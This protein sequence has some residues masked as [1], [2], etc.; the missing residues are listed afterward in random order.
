MIESPGARAG[1]PSIDSG[2]DADPRGG[3]QPPKTPEQERF[4]TVFRSVTVELLPTE[5]QWKLLRYRATESMSYRN[6]HMQAVAANACGWE[7]TAAAI[8]RLVEKRPNLEWKDGVLGNGII[9]LVRN[10]EKGELSSN[11]Y[12]AAEAEVKKDW[13]RDQR[14]ILAGAPLPQYRQDKSLAIATITDRAGVVFTL[15]TYKDAKGVNRERFVVDLHVSDK[16]YEGGGWM[17]IPVHS[18]A[19]YDR[20]KHDPFVWSRLLAFANE[21][22]PIDLGRV[23]FKVRRGKTLLQISYQE[24]VPIP[25]PGE[26]VA[27]LTVYGDED[28]RL[29]L[30]SELHSVDLT[31]QLHRFLRYKL[32]YEGFRRRLSN[33]LGRSYRNRRSK[34][35]KFDSYNFPSWTKTHFQSLA[36]Y[37]IKWCLS[38]HVH[39]LKVLDLKGGDWPEAEFVGYL[40]DCGARNSLSVVRITKITEAASEEPA[41]QRAV[42]R[43]VD[44]ERLKRKQL[45]DAENTIAIRAGL[46]RPRSRKKKTDEPPTAV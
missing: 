2:S 11:C 42:K 45:Q 18:G 13:R 12:L 4:V 30:R 10:E 22:V 41:I 1:E 25:V 46:G 26:R 35:E 14:K 9:K 15:T 36:S 24:E 32:Q 39:F 29:V 23:L 31:D 17:S 34:L 28:R 5:E 19:R 7:L 8:Q 16:D 3:L 21:Q 33:Q 44:R 40:L 43:E 20:E 37:I 38:E 6:K 27:S